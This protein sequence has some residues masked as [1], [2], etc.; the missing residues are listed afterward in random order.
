[1]SPKHSARGIVLM[2]SMPTT[3]I[4]GQCML[5]NYEV[6]GVHCPPDEQYAHASIHAKCK[7]LSISAICTLQM[8]IS[9]A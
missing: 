9:C 4:F 2:Q 3:Y 1:M 6:S 7:T 5:V 8:F